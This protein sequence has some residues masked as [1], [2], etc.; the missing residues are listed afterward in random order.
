MID[1]DSSSDSQN[2]QEKNTSTLSSIHPRHARKNGTWPQYTGLNT[3]LRGKIYFSD[4]IYP[5]DKWTNWE[6]KLIR[7]VDLSLQTPE[8]YHETHNHYQNVLSEVW[9]FTP[10][11]NAV[12]MWGDSAA[13]AHSSLA[14]GGF[15]SARSSYTQRPGT[16]QDAFSKALPQDIN[17]STSREE[18]DCQLTGLEVDV[19]NGGKPGLP[20]N[21]A[22]HGITIVGFGNPNSHALSVICENFDCAEELR[23]GQFEAGLYF[24][25]SIHPDYG[26]VLVSD[27]DR[28]RMGL[29]FRSTLF[30]EGA[31]CLRSS[32]KHTGVRLNEGAG[33]EIYVQENES[34]NGDGY[35]VIQP[36][37]DGL[38]L[39]SPDGSREIIRITSDGS[40][41]LNISSINI[42]NLNELLQNEK[43]IPRD[44]PKT[45]FLHHIASWFFSLIS[46]PA[47][48]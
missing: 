5:D 13:I 6:G 47:P 12:A 23:R 8:N 21:K 4:I 32:G 31:V 22:K 48:R 29:D 45:N 11:T 35:T 33:G 40:I 37:R 26:R 44:E 16:P 3:R 43:R 1:E 25:N 15:F 30:N 36:G 9:N 27:M 2:D 42:S 46:S 18:F 34:K 38:I 7:P 19:L 10:G 28:A 24:Q 41:Q 17:S 14:W 39:M 20:G